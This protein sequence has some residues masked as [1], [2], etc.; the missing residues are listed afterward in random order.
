MPP[1]QPSNPLCQSAEQTN[2]SLAN[3]AK[4]F[5]AFIYNFLYTCSEYYSLYRCSVK[6]A[7]IILLVLLNYCET[8]W[9]FVNTFNTLV[10]AWTA[11]CNL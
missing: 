7:E 10:K 8:S 1:L 9:T 4:R 6:S 3:N 5:A 11:V 2:P